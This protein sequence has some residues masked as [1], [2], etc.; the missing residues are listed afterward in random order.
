MIEMSV[1]HYYVNKLLQYKLVLGALLSLR[2]SRTASNNVIQCNLT[3]GFKDWN[4]VRGYSY[5]LIVLTK[6]HVY[7]MNV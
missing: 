6:L 3:T 2:Y 5:V 4:R 1:Q 7:I